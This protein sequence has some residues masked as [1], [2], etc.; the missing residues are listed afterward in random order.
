MLYYIIQ[1]YILYYSF[2]LLLFILILLSFGN[3]Y[4][5]E[6]KETASRNR[7]SSFVIFKCRI[8][9][10]KKHEILFSFLSE[11]RSAEILEK[12]IVR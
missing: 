10:E 12:K 9:N 7:D 11:K 6:P 2:L 4:F 5:K 8:M 3:V 1:C